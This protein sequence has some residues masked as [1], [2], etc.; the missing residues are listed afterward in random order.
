MVG[1]GGLR[2]ARC[3][4][5]MVRE[6]DGHVGGLLATCGACFG[7]RRS[8][9]LVELAV[10]VLSLFLSYSTTA[11]FQLLCR[12][13][14]DAYLT[15]ATARARPNRRRRFDLRLPDKRHILS[16][17]STA[18][19]HCTAVTRNTH[20]DH[21]AAVSWLYSLARDP[22]GPTTAKRQLSSSRAY[23]SRYEPISL[24]PCTVHPGACRARCPN[25]HKVE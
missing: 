1:L 24:T 14:G 3:L 8:V 15:Q 20:N 23:I 9:E 4:R 18:F 12:G 6:W 5:R 16:Q 22:A 25:S 11:G 13:Q 21:L 10:P 7:C 19:E 17:A 2:A